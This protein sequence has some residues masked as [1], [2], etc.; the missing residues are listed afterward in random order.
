MRR[1]VIMLVV[2][3]AIAG[4]SGGCT[5]KAA[6]VRGALA[7]GYGSSFSAWSDA[8]MNLVRRGSL[9]P[10]GPQPRAVQPR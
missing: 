6:G 3:V 9:H 8:R 5:S 4:M 10:V 1:R 2:L 7:T